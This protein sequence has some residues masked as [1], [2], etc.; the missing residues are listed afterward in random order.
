MSGSLECR[1]ERLAEHG[2]GKWLE[3][4]LHRTVF[5]KWLTET[6][7]RGRCNENDGQ[8]TPAARQFPLQIRA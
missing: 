7:I 8:C 3:Q 1:T 2:L 4:T 5:E 6:F